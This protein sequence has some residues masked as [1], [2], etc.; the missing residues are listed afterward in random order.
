MGYTDQLEISNRDLRR[1][2]MLVDEHGATLL[3]LDQGRDSSHAKGGKCPNS[4]P[5]C[6]LAVLLL[7]SA[8][9]G[10][11]YSQQ[12][13]QESF[14]AMRWRLIG[15]HRAGR[16]TAVS[17]AAGEPNTFYIGTPGGG[18]WKTEDA[19]Q[20]WTPIFDQE[21]IA[22]I[23]ALAVSRSSPNVI[24]VGTGEQIAGNGVYKSIDSGKTWTNVGLNQTRFITSVLVDPRNPDLVLVAAQGQA[25][26]SPDR[27]VFKS[28]DGGKTWAK[29]LFKDDKT[30]AM[31]L[32][33]A[34]DDP[35]IV[36]A[37]MSEASSLRGARAPTAQGPDSAIYRST[38]EGASWQPVAGKALPEKGLG[39]VGV[40][41]AP[42]TGGN[43]VYAILAQGLFRSEDGGAS[44]ERATV[45]PRIEGSWY[46]SRV[47]VD[48]TNANNVYVSQTSMYRSTD[49]GKTFASYQ[50]APS[51]DD[52]HV[53]WIDPL[54]SQHII[55]GVD[56]GAVISVNGGRTWSSWYN[57]P[58]GQFYHV[59]T[60]NEFP[61]RVYAAQQDSGTAAVISRG[62]NG[63]I[64]FRD[65]F[66]VAG[67]EAC[68]IVPDPNKPNIIYAGGWYGSVERFDRTTGQ[69]AHVFVASRKYRTNW[70]TPLVLSPQ[71][72]HTIYFGAQMV[73]KTSDEGKS[74][75]EI[76]PDL[77]TVEKKEGGEDGAEPEPRRRPGVLTV[78]APSK[79]AGGVLWAGTSTGLIQLTRDNGSTWKN[80]S[81]T[82]LPGIGS[83]GM[84]EASLFDS[85]E[86]YA[87]VTVENGTSPLI[88]R[89]RDFGQTWQKTT[90]G[91]P[92][93]GIARVVREDPARKGLL[94]A[95][96]EAG[97]FVS[98]DD[99]DHWQPLQL[100]LPASS[101]RDLDV[102]GSDLIAATF[103]RALWVLDD[104]TPLRQANSE[105]AAA[106]LYHPEPAVRARWD[107]NPDT[108]LQPETP[109]G[110]NPPDGAIIDYYLKSG[111]G[112]AKLDIYDKSGNHVRG[113]SNVPEPAPKLPANAPEYW[114]AQEPAL[115]THS[116]VNRFVWDLRYPHPDTLPYGYYGNLLDYVEYTLP[117]HA[118][119]GETPRYQPQGR[120][121]APGEYQ[122]VLTIEG[123]TYKQMLT[124]KP[125]PRVPAAQEDFDQQSALAES[126]AAQMKIS[127]AMFYQVQDLR[128]A[129]ADRK[130]ALAA[131]AGADKA[132]AAINA[133][134]NKM[135]LLGPERR[136]VFGLINRDQA[137][138]ITM[139]ETADVRPSDSATRAA[140]DLCALLKAFLGIWREVNVKDIPALNALLEK[141][142]LAALKVETGIPADTGCAK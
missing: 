91:L 24:Y 121:V 75:Q 36:Y 81:V 123:K 78:L 134:E 126:I 49:A 45:D 21:R 22:S 61:Y 140:S 76:S 64:T 34:P 26:S 74:W 119:P 11:A 57:Q 101:V 25:P 79:A 33:W 19:G 14:K 5:R 92:D 63:E 55:M 122:I 141:Y 27:G 65:W 3:G 112:D 68:F 17:G 70:D 37:A 104:L 72:S 135:A 96:T 137:R 71:D 129:V 2:V 125:D 42:G 130:K 73:L 20:V 46:F 1:L 132:S 43:R 87:T 12:Y 102:H 66:P 116:G 105:V 109:A 8:L 127:A 133:L 67:F 110:T 23:G 40:D 83:I 16:V 94:Y 85:A 52:Y 30:S 89:T 131:I 44:W 82:G 56:Q 77:T 99:G 6:I 139:V 54:N 60:D 103:G 53:L 128:E 48:P 29:T 111:T 95:G 117:D 142:K 88:Y 35:H 58:T 32:C 28:T 69:Y 50:G 108:P 106:R 97:V 136:S 100:N 7:L 9:A 84:I 80:V 115:S 114:F 15:P 124:V 51:G 18:V 10:S 90:E 31:D 120:L 13:D 4:L 59:S 138:L 86:A 98:F 113:F 38:D 107:V 39:R 41:V 62:D 47:F 118:I 93:P